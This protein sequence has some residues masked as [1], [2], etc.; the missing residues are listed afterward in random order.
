MW[1]PPFLSC[2]AQR[3]GAEH[4]F[5]CV[6]DIT[7]NAIIATH[8]RVKCVSSKIPKF[9]VLLVATYNIVVE[10]FFFSLRWEAPPYRRQPLPPPFGRPH[11][12]HS[13]NRWIWIV[14]LPFRVFRTF[15]PT[16]CPEGA[17]LKPRGVSSQPQ[18]LLHDYHIIVNII[19]SCKRRNFIVS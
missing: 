5:H 19:I 2:S 7:R 10:K 16:R 9:S 12:F 14:F 17:I 15:R 6:V 1:K 13:D 11:H 3:T 4:K 8:I 18:R